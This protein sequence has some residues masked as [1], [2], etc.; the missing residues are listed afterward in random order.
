MLLSAYDR[1]VCLCV[2]RRYEQEKDR[3]EAMLRSKGVHH[4]E[5]FIDGLGWLL[6]PAMYDQITPVQPSGWSH[7]VG[8]YAHFTAMQTIVRDAKREGVSNLLF[9]EDDCVFS[10]D[11]DEVLRAATNQIAERGLDWDL[12]YYG[13]NHTWASTEELA[14]NLLRC[15]GSYTTHCMGIPAKTFDAILGLP[16]VHVID[17]V[18]ANHLHPKL[19]CLAI[20]PAIAVQKPG[21]SFLSN[22]PCDYSELF[23]SK[24][25]TVV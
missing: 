18:I 3:V 14:P 20:Y 19:N 11:F 9:V 24:G 15:F 21:F 12:L 6:D 16:P 22:Q 10:D 17:W 4:V 13:A 1:V 2:D 7:G 5:W 23:K 8:A 25:K